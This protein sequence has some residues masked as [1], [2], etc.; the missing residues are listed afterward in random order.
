MPALTEQTVRDRIAELE[1]QR[2]E[3]IQNANAQ[4]AALNGAIQALTELVTE[5]KPDGRAA[6]A[7]EVA[8]EHH[9][10]GCSG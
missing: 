7:R 1:K 8:D 4:V 9:E 6:N 2:D 10:H 5:Q 3:F